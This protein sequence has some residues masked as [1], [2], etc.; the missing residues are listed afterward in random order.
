MDLRLFH[1]E[2]REIYVTPEKIILR[3]FFSAIVLCEIVAIIPEI[4]RQDLFC[5]SI[6]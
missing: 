2:L 4:I 3:E 1:V 5:V 6:L